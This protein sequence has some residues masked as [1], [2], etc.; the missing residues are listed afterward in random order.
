MELVYSVSCCRPAR[1]LATS[2]VCE[3]P[4]VGVV[5]AVKLSFVCLYFFFAG[6]CGGVAILSEIIKRTQFETED[7]RIITLRWRL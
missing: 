7:V 3:V 1:G 5:L 2:A 4:G 6:E